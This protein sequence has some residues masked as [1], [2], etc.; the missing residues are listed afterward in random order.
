MALAQSLLCGASVLILDE[1]T[2]H[3]DV[4]STQVMERALTLLPG[5][6]IVVSHDRFFIDKI[7]TRL[8][9]IEG[10]GVVNEVAGSWTIWHTTR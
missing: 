1:P 7:A 3:L 6:V 9:V 5:A 2:N 8:L 4:T 10:E